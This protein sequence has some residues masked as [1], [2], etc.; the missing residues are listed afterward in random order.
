MRVAQNRTA[1][2]EAGRRGAV[3]VGLFIA[4]C[5]TVTPAR[6]AGIDVPPGLP[7]HFAI[8][9]S[10]HPDSSG[11][12]GWMPGTGVPWDYAYQY[13][14]A[15]VN[16]G[17]GW[18][19]W[20]SNGQFVTYYCQGAGARGCI[21]TFPYYQMLQSTGTCDSCGESERDLSN[22][23]N[24]SLMQDYYRDFILL[25]KRLGPGTHDGI[26]G[27][28]K[29]AIVN[30]EPDLIGYAQHA[31]L[32]NSSSCYGFCSGQG[33]DA[34]FLKAAV[35]STGVAET[36]GF[37]NTF[38][39]FNLALLHIR[40]LYAPNVLMAIHLSNWAT[41]WDVGS[42]TDP[43]LD[44]A[45][46]GR[47]AGQFLNSCGV[48]EIRADVSR[49]D[50]VFNDVADRDAGY[51]TYVLGRSNAFWDRAN[52][53]LPHFHRWEA[54]VKAAFGVTG[55]PVIVWQ[56]PLGNQYFRTMDN[57]WG[58]YQDNRAE[59]FL[60]HVNELIGA[61]V[62]GL[63]FGCGNS[64]STTQW[65]DMGDGITNPAS[66]CTTDGSSGGEICNTHS[67][68]VAD[69][70]GGY[71]RM[72]AAEY[73]KNPVVIG[74]GG[75]GNKA[76]EADAGEG[77]SV[78]ASAAVTLDGSGS[79]DPNG[80]ALT[81]R[82]EQLSGVAVT[83]DSATAAR[84]RF[85][86]PAAAATLVFRLTVSDGAL[87]DTDDVTVVVS[88]TPGKVPFITSISCKSCRPGTFATIRGGN[89]SSNKK[90]VR[91]VFGTKTAKISKTTITSVKV[92][93]PKKLKKGVPVGVTVWVSGAPSNTVVFVP[94]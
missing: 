16:T 87:T 13:L 14:C 58:H 71:I 56:I 84:P 85:T 9:V 79:S 86:A 43:S 17:N 31:V 93:I 21:P 47:Q 37:P 50:L 10:A 78:A 52:A 74:G 19:T 15:G 54:Y 41:R 70:D 80:D 6:S 63:Q 57:S 8:G 90:V 67:S 65:D 38:A 46:L 72:A 42:S 75:G 62:I 29:T 11:L 49:Y 4:G 30:V 32:A 44:V 48:A 69:D 26:P 68:T 94:K 40:D 25:M 55:R 66:F 33:N 1:S 83:L 23:N 35:A 22:L 28:G 24:V 81:Y 3:L 76:P 5:L 53:V 2:S 27:Y 34:S 61:G 36:A 18:A 51:Y 7:P 59:Y 20:N 89:F 77:Q 92:T 39:G 12:Y 64:G 88:S 45:A 91:V 73:Y 60:G 82:W